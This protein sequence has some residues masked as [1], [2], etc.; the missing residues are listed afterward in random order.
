[1]A[2][3]KDMEPRWPRDSNYQ[4]SS[5]GRRVAS[6]IVQRKANLD[7]QPQLGQD[8]S[9]LEDRIITSFRG[10]AEPSKVT[11]RSNL[12]ALQGQSS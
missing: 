4:R 6:S 5:I 11:R 7:R 1:M 12:L 8:R 2:T 10:G 3:N 9:L